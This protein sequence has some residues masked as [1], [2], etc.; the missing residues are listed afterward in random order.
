MDPGSVQAVFPQVRGQF[1]RS[2]CPGQTTVDQVVSTRGPEAWSRRRQAWSWS[3]RGIGGPV[4]MHHVPVTLGAAWWVGLGLGLG[5]GVAWCWTGLGA[6]GHW[7]VARCCWSGCVFAVAPPLTCMFACSLTFGVSIGGGGGDFFWRCLGWWEGVLGVS[8]PSAWLD[9][10]VT[11]LRVWYLGSRPGHI[12]PP[13]GRSQPLHPGLGERPD[14]GPDHYR[15]SQQGETRPAEG[16]T[17]TPGPRT[18]GRPCDQRQGTRRFGSSSSSLNQQADESPL[19]GSRNE[20]EP[21][22]H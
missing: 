11:G 8:R 13:G 4:V 3:W 17:P 18:G 16:D 20:E 7:W 12:R 6:A 21:T 22:W 19:R 5:L 2:R 10:S 15:G 9:V 14:R 1:G